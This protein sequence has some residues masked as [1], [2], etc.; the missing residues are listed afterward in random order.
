MQPLPLLQVALSD[1]IVV[2]SI[3]ITG[4][5]LIRL[6]FNSLSW[7]ELL[8]L[9]FPIGAG[10][11]TWVWFIT[12]W[13][14]IPINRI[15]LILMFLVVNLI[16]FALRRAF[17]RGS[18]FSHPQS[19]LP[20]YPSL[21]K[22]DVTLMAILMIAFCVSSWL[23]ISR[24]Y[25]VYDGIA[26]WAPK[27]YGIALEQSI[28]GAHWGNHDLSYPLQIHFLIA[29]FRLFSGDILPGS[30]IIFPLYHFSMIL[31]I[32]S[33]LTKRR[34]SPAFRTPAVIILLTVPTLFRFST[35]GYA[36]LPMAATFTLAFLWGIEGVEQED[37]R[38]QFLSGLLLAFTVWMIIEGVLYAFIAVGV[39]LLTR[40][41]TGKGRIWIIAWLS[42]VLIIGGTWFLFFQLFGST[43]SQALDAS[44]LM[45]S[46]LR[47][48]DYHLGELRLILGY[49][50]RN[51]FDISTW[52]LIYPLSILLFIWNWKQI[53]P[54]NSFGG[55]ALFAATV[56]SGSLSLGLFFLRS[57]YIPGLYDLLERGFPRGFMVP[58]ILFFCLTLLQHKSETHL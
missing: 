8:S 2:L 18:S 48:G 38:L 25:S 17:F 50:R 5:Q 27:G 58:T 45:F 30:K 21:S 33:Y 51:I 52:G 26:M 49:T 54:Q 44:E 16:L 22:A 53:L 40:S 34:V 43:N 29:A 20:G 36:N 13:A 35:I 31:G 41:L 37:R 10:V 14:G 6:L 46:A 7:L 9:V 32:Y 47:Q 56:L 4:Y 1:L 11:L 28:W 55:F 39:L 24:S 15:I 42:P 12:G 3:L 19:W 57:F 23:A